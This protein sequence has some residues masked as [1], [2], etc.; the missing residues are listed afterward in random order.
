MDSVSSRSAGTWIYSVET[1]NAGTR[2][3]ERDRR[4]Y[5]SSIRSA[6]SVAER[7]MGAPLD[8]CVCNAGAARPGLFLEDLTEE[9]FSA[10]IDVNYLGVVHTLKA[11]LPGMVRRKSGAV[12][13]VS[14]GLALTGYAGY[15]ARVRR[16]E[17]SLTNRGD[18]AAA[19]WI[20]R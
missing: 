5:A 7:S 8:A 20:F 4:R 2:T 15:G 19:T 9:D 16:A 12:A 14:S 18:D 11:A 13:L 10:Q 17:L 6:V 1:S 3:Y